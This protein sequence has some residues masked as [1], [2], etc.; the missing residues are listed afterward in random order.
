MNA[1]ILSG[2]VVSKAEPFPFKEGRLCVKFTL[3]FSR[4]ERPCSIEVATYDDLAKKVLSRLKEGDT[5][6]L[7][8]SLNQYTNKK[9]EKVHEVIAGEIQPIK[10]SA[11]AVSP[12]IQPEPVK[13][14]E[15]PQKEEKPLPQTVSNDLLGTW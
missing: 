15:P 13:A 3:Q 5:I 4:K 2:V 14:P 12:E 1:Q 8:G 7:Q 10:I 11:P 6:A 9:G